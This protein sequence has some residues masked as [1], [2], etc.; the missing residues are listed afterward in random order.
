MS[1]AAHHLLDGRGRV[2]AR[3]YRAA[4]GFDPRNGASGGSR[5]DDVD[6]GFEGVG[7]LR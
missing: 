1:N 6:R 2:E 4:E 5:H 3:C 7:I